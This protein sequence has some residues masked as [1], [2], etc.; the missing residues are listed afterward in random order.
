MLLLVLVLVSLIRLP[1]FILIGGAW[2]TTEAYG[3]IVL[4]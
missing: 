1:I 3:S 2:P 4:A